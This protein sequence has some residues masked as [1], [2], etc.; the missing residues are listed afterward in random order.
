LLARTLGRAAL[1][2]VLLTSDLVF[3]FFLA[4]LTGPLLLAAATGDGMAWLMKRLAEPLPEPRR[5]AWRD[6]VEGR[7]LPLRQKLNRRA[8]ATAAKSLLQRGLSWVFEKCGTLSPRAALIVIAGVML[9]LPLSVAISTAMH[10]VLIAKAASWPAWMQLLHPVA[11]AIAKS[12]LLI[13]PAYPAAWPQA[14]KHAIVQAAFRWM[15]R[16]AAL[17]PFRKAAHRYRQSRQAFAK[18]GNGVARRFT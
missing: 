16:I 4:V 12:K 13:L 5:E 6:A 10:V 17:A 3:A 2:L 18:A 8:V 15:E 1:L 7:W 9:W 11:T 14:R